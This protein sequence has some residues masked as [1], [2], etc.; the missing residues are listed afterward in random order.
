MRVSPSQLKQYKECPEAWRLSYGE[1]LQ[2][3]RTRKVFEIGTYTHQLLHV[4][5][6]TLKLGYKPGSDFVIDMMASRIKSDLRD[7][8][9]DN[10][11]IMSTVL[12]L[13]TRFVKEQS[14][15]IDSGIEVIAV[16]HEFFTEVEGITLHG[17][18]DLVYR[19]RAGNVWIRDHKTSAQANS[20]YNDKLVMDE[21]LALYAYA[22][23]IELGEPV[24]R[25]EVNFLNTYQYKDPR[26]TADMFKSFKHSHTELSLDNW[27]KNL[28]VL[29][30]QMEQPEQYRNYSNACASCRFFQIC[31]L[32]TRGIP[33][34]GIKKTYFS[35]RNH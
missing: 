10:A 3:N 16:E 21:Q 26:P 23:S 33:V 31:S 28:Q 7:V 22:M 24:L 15:K 13:V 1:G 19:D 25:V 30:K 6:Q 18:I 9:A 32:D 2:V 4:L 17:F 20:W 11:I 34:D 12:P 14:P 27:F 8:D 29:H 35:E 5:Y